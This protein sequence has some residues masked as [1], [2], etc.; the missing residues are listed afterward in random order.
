MYG[1]FTYIYHKNQP[2]AGKYTTHYTWM[3][4][5]TVK[6]ALR[7]RRPRVFDPQ[8]SCGSA[9]KV[10]ASLSVVVAW[11]LG[12]GRCYEVLELR[13]FQ[14]GF[15]HRNKRGEYG[16]FLEFLGYIYM[17]YS[18]VCDFLSHLFLCFVSCLCSFQCGS[19]NGIYVFFKCFWVENRGQGLCMG[20]LWAQVNERLSSS[21][22]P[23]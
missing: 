17:L 4:W 7:Q 6:T 19:Q 22:G 21:D 13:V 9:V 3:V 15:G 1:I 8:E 5:V 16:C 23:F 10:I 12:R 20:I 2:N 18:L 11:R 14:A